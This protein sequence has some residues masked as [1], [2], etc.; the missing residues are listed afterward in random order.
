MKKVLLGLLA[1]SAVSMAAAPNLGDDPTAGTNVFQNLQEGA[2]SI[3]GT[4]T[5]KVPVVKYVVFASEDNGVTK[6]D[7]LMLKD[8]ILATDST[9]G[10]ISA[11]PKVYVKRVVGAAGAEDYAELEI[12]DDVSFKYEA[13]SFYSDVNN[14]GWIAAGGE[15]KSIHALS[16]LSKDTLQDAINLTGVPGVVVTTT[17]TIATTNAAAMYKVGMQLHFRSPVSGELE[18]AHMTSTSTVPAFTA[19]TMTK[20]DNAFA[21]GKAITNAKILVKV[22]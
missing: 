13:D 22:D 3:T 8:F 9:S 4:L 5:S 6:E 19:P 21:G 18:V 20:F 11:N 1:L 14:K 16:L 7:T 17:G 2:I 10:F 15:V 12:G